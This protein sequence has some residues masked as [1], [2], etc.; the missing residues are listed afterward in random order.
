MRAVRGA[1]LAASSATLAIGA[2]AVAHGGMP[3]AAMTVAMTALIGWSATGLA[4][5]A[6][7]T[8][9]TLAALGVAQLLMHLVLTVVDDH[10]G[11]V[12]VPLDPVAM[13][14]A[15]AVA[16][17]LTALLLAHAERG[18]LAFAASLR[19]LLQVRCPRLADDPP[20]GS[21][22]VAPAARGLSIEVLLRRVRPPRGPPLCS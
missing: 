8:A 17:V 2:H 7:S 11:V 21:V 22:A 9:S 14:G 20:V 6:R 3:D 15:H 10:H 4:D 13:T 12:A 18:L 16:T 19:G 1:L 5:R